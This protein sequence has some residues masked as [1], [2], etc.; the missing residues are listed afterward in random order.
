MAINFIKKEDLTHITRTTKQWETTVDR[1]EII[2][3]GVLCIELC[4]DKLTKIK[5]GNGHQIY[6]KLPYVSGIDLSDYY[7]KEETDDLLRELKTVKI[8][9]E[10]SSLSDLPLSGNEEGDIYF[11][12]KTS[13]SQNDKYDEY[14]WFKNNWESWGSS[15]IDLSE[16]AKKEYVDQHIQEVQNEITEILESGYLHKHNNKNVLDQTSAVYNTEK[17]Q[18][19]DSLHNYD[20]TELRAKSHTHLNKNILDQIDAVYNRD[21]DDKLSS[22]ENY[23]DTYIQDRLS[24]LEQ[25]AHFHD[26]MDVLNR[27]TAA[28]TREQAM[29]LLDCKD[30]EGATASSNGYHGFVPAPMKADREHFLR[31]DGVWAEV[32]QGGGDTITEGGGI[33]IT[34]DSQTGV[35]TVSVNVGTGLEVDQQTGELNVTSEG[36]TYTFESNTDGSFTVT[37][38][39]EDPQVVTTYEHPTYT[40]HQSGLYVITVDETGHISDASAATANDLP[41]HTHSY[42]GSNEAGGAATSANKLNIGNSDIGSVTHPVYFDKTTGLPVETTYELNKS[43]PADALFTDTIYT[44][45][46]YTPHSSG[47]YKVT[48]DSTGHVSN[49]ESVQGSDLPSH[50]HTVS[51]ITDF[52]TLGTASSYDVP[53]SGDAANDEVVLGN[54]SR[55]TDARTPVSHTHTESDITDLGP[56]AEGATHNGAAVSSNK[57]NIGNS[58]IGSTTQPVYFDKTSGLPVAIGYTIEKSVPSDA[59][60]T[61]TTYDDF[62]GSGNNHAHGLV[63]DPGS[64]AGTS[65]YLC[66]NGSWAVPPGTYSHPTHTPAVSGLYKVTVDAL[67]HVSAT[68]SVQG[69][70][71]PS[72]EHTVSDITDFP[73]LGTASSYD[74]P[75]S[76]NAG[77]DEVVLGNDSRL[78]DARTPTAHEHTISDITDFGTYADGDNDGAALSANMLNI[79]ESDVGSSTQP[80]YFD[81]TTGLPVAID[82]TIE[83]SV[84]ENAVFTDTTYNDFG[85][86]GNNHSNGLVP[87]P[88]STAGTSRFLREDGGWEEPPSYELPIAG[89]AILGGIKIGDG[90][91]INN[92]GVAS[93]NKMD[94]FRVGRGL[95]MEDESVRLPTGYYKAKYVESD[96]YAYTTIPFTPASYPNAKVI[97]RAMVTGVRPQYNQGFL[98]G[99]TRSNNWTGHFNFVLSTKTTS[100]DSAVV[101]RFYYGDMYGPV[102]NPPIETGY[103]IGDILDFEM[104]APDGLKINNETIHSITSSMSGLSTPYA[105]AIFGLS[106][107]SN[108]D[109]ESKARIYSLKIYN[110][111]T[112]LHNLV[113][114]YRQS[115]EKVGF[116]NTVNST[117]YTSA[118]SSHPFT[119]DL[120]DLDPGDPDWVLKANIATTSSIGEVIVGNGLSVAA[121]GTVSAKPMGASGT[122]HSAGMVPDPGST[123]GSS[124]FLCENGT[125]AEPSIEY[126]A[127]NAI[128]ID[129]LVPTLYSSNA[130]IHSINTVINGSFLKNNDETEIT[131][132]ATDDDCYTEDL[133]GQS[134]GSYPFA[135]DASTKYRLTW[136]IDDDTVSG[137]V[138]IFENGLSTIVHT[139]DQSEAT[140][141]EFTTDENTTF[142][143]T[144]FGITNNG[145]SYTLSNVNL[146]RCS[147]NAI[148][149]KYGDGLTVNN[150]NELDVKIGSGL[151]FDGS[152]TINLTAGE[153]INIGNVPSRKVLTSYSNSS[154]ISNIYYAVNGSF[155][156]NGNNE[157]VTLT[158]SGNDCYTIQ[159]Y[160]TSNGSYPYNVKG[161]TP[162]R[163]EWDT[164]DTDG[165]V[166]GNVMI[167]ENG[168]YTYVH[169]VN[170]AVAHY[171]D[172]TTQSGTTYIMTRLGVSKRNNSIT[173]SNFRLYEFTEVIED[174]I[175]VKH[176]DGL[177]V[178]R[179]NELE[180]S[181]GQ[182]LSFDANGAINVESTVPFAAGVGLELIPGS[183][184]EDALPEGY[185]KVDYVESNGNGYTIINYVPNRNSKIVGTALFRSGNRDPVV[186]GCRKGGGNGK[187]FV[188]WF[189]NYSS[190]Q[191]KVGFVYGTNTWDTS[192]DANGGRLIPYMT[193]DQ[194]SFLISVDDDCNV[195]N[196]FVHNITNNGAPATD[197]NLGIFAL[198]ETNSSI[199]SDDTIFKGRIYDFKIYEND[200]LVVNLVPAVRLLDEKVGFYD[201]IN[202]LFYTSFSPSNQFTTDMDSMV[203]DYQDT[204]LNTRLGTGLKM[205]LDNKIETNISPGQGIDIS[206]DNQSANQTGLLVST[207][208]GQGL[209]YNLN[210]E[211]EI[212]TGDGLQFDTNDKLTLDLQTVLINGNGISITPQTSVLPAGYGQL[213]YIE[214]TGQQWTQLDYVATH[215][216]RVVVDCISYETTSTDRALFGCREGTGG[217]PQFILWAGNKSSNNVT[218]SFVYGSNVWDDDYNTGVE[219]EERFTVD[220][221]YNGVYINGD[222]FESITDQGNMPAYKVALFTVANGDGTYIT[223]KG[224]GK[225]RIFSFKIYE[226]NDLVVDLVPAISTSTG[227]GLYDVVNDK[228]YT[229]LTATPFV[230][231]PASVVY[232][233]SY[234]VATKIG[235]GLQYDSNGAIEAIPAGLTPATSSTLGGVIVGNGLTVAS[236]GTIS[237]ATGKT[238]IAGEGINMSSSQYE[239]SAENEQYLFRSQV[240]CELHGNFNREFQKYTDD[241]ALGMVWNVYDSGTLW[242]GPMFVGLSADAVKY[243][244][245]STTYSSLGTFSY[246]GKTWY[247]SDTQMYVSNID[248]TDYDGNMVVDTETYASTSDMVQACKSLID[249]ARVILKVDE[250]SLLPATE[251]TLGGIKIGEGLSIDENNVVSSTV[252][253]EGQGI[254]FETSGSTDSFDVKNKQYYF[255]DEARCEITGNF[256]PRTF[257]RVYTDDPCLAVIFYRN[258]TTT[259]PLYIGLTENSVK[260]YQSWDGNVLGPSDTFDYKGYTWYFT[261]DYG[262][263]YSSGVD[264]LNHLQTISGTSSDNLV[265]VAKHVIDLAELIN[266]GIKTYD[267]WNTGTGWLNGSYADGTSDTFYTSWYKEYHSNNTE[268]FELPKGATE[269][270]LT[271]IS[272]SDTAFGGNRIDLF[273]DAKHHIG[274]FTG[275]SQ[276]H[277]L[278]TGTVYLQFG[279]KWN[280][281]NTQDIAGSSVKSVTLEIKVPKNNAITAKLGDGLT[282]DEN[283]AITLDESIKLIIHCVGTP[284]T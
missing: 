281:Q 165:S 213:S 188:F 105:F 283:D 196:S 171:I 70:D 233:S 240:T 85:G 49:A 138:K 157:S 69:S 66:E 239:F 158:A 218:A 215:D 172:F 53:E 238:Y 224:M 156:K 51:D 205:S 280:E 220:A 72:H 193:G 192:T 261:Y 268:Y 228:F 160:N 95:T 90:I 216:S 10:A 128:D 129:D 263:Y 227:V 194:F 50:G 270:K 113:P 204:T 149:V 120:T 279:V 209:K 282:F 189:N 40:T 38:D 264:Q 214:G 182:G 197:L 55:L 266:P 34:T 117:F 200:E 271:G 58:N 127:G 76:G 96:G 247:Y 168:G 141:L 109:Y 87:D 47:L 111:D 84:P 2:P 131:I 170:Q 1:Y 22:L 52:P 110:G 202:D 35:K 254:T 119:T 245:N 41:A 29:I 201:N 273:N 267:V 219:L 61:D 258:D 106:S 91:D 101:S 211:I 169:T 260:L 248:G 20:D 143:T 80:V 13:P 25:V 236:D 284:L 252:Y 107:A 235:S 112:L 102:D 63:P 269:V 46:S 44:H 4:N 122:S 265:N 181:L 48:V 275:E 144:R 64:E 151:S 272:T 77:N 246:L 250:I 81:S 54:D 114:A 26:N 108:I 134:N 16:Y 32:Q 210:D 276:W 174:A 121:D 234:Q 253:E 232:P 225:Y 178:N 42:A 223:D 244:A 97:G 28:F 229:S 15:N 231:D 82:Y 115:D 208:L 88:G 74:V 152:G 175:S 71:L 125:W 132:T 242:S 173:Y 104:S 67:G 274:T 167:F 243:T 163:L 159:T 130:F 186:F 184:S 191:A 123:Q 57:L 83:T 187:Q 12:P 118:N 277:E 146:Y 65:K 79:G 255:E 137:E 147:T 148:S 56:Y 93:V 183:S 259:A 86:S 154:L 140:Y 31:G 21:K 180:V 195:N 100:A 142:I 43:V 185:G 161:D 11:I 9:G 27:T 207:K 177:T 59:V 39:G 62:V 19:L 199:E 92:N 222:L 164:D 7:T 155:T 60:F 30:F 153:A 78:T 6:E 98:F 198:A 139:V 217:R 133:V 237:T 179:D 249:R 126:N 24:V 212:D 45:P 226:G 278:L 3:K 5:I 23:D 241:T 256:G 68:E 176:G 262:L 18:K 166:D 136:T 94:P 103:S 89:P 135:V 221:S 203:I 75:E 257:W 33:S 17:D 124:K 162:Y 116:Y 8:K 37:P 251:D 99:V 150:D 230:Y 73:T 190:N 206:V 36:T 145:D 14:I